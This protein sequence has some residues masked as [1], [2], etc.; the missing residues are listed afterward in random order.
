M[1]R[2]VDGNLLSGV[3][4]AVMVGRDLVD[5]NCVGWADKEA[6]TPLRRRPYLSRILQHQAGHVLRRAAAVRGRQIWARRSHREIHSAAWQP[7]GSAPRRHFA[8][9]DRAGQE[10]DHHPSAA[11]PQFRPELR[12][13]RSRHRHLQGLQRARRPQSHDDAGADGRRAGRSAADLSAG[14]VVGILARHR[15]GGAAGRSHQRPDAS[16]IHPGADSRSARHGRH[17]LRRAGEGSGPAGRVLRRRGPDG[18]DEAGTDPNRQLRPSPAPI[19]VPSHGSMAAAA[20]S[21]PCPTWWR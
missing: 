12:L 9:R 7:E 11:E 16:T 18:A 3:S 14:D 4:S 8:G 17:R 1:Q 19:C 15:R 6:Q 21:R 5:V 20:W 13:L 10:L 2:Y